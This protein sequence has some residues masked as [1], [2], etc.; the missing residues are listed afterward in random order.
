MKLIKK[1][2]AWFLAMVMTL[3][4]ASGGLSAFAVVEDIT[5]IISHFRLYDETEHALQD[6]DI[7]VAKPGDIIAVTYA[8]QN[9]ASSRFN[10]RGWQQHI[11]FN[12]SALAYY[13][14]DATDDPEDPQGD[15]AEHG[16]KCLL[17]MTP[18]V[19][20]P[21]DGVT[22]VSVASSAN[23]GI[24]KNS[25][26]DV[27]V[28]LYKVL[29]GAS[30]NITIQYAQDDKDF[31][32][33]G[34]EKAT[35][36]SLGVPYSIPVDNPVPT[37]NVKISTDIK[38]GS[39]TSNPD[40]SAQEGATVTLTVAPASGYRLKADSLKVTDASGDVA[41]TDAGKT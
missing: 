37:H 16:Y 29:D 39:V 10:F 12:A 2:G 27:F 15:F 1:A 33:V 38:N 24:S 19:G 21:S 41:L 8:L 6:D 3:N 20:N 40:K 36:Y 22:T 25:S 4:V 34:D 5:C 11:N 28:V 23:V 18:S 14:K 7:T 31:L 32:A 26:L 30:G 35:G 9:N 17:T 13:E